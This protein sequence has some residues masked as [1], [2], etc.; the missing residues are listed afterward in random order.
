MKHSVFFQWDHITYSSFHNSASF[1]T[2]PRKLESTEIYPCH[3][4]TTIIQQ[5]YAHLGK[6][7]DY[8]L[9][10]SSHVNFSETGQ[11]VTAV[12]RETSARKAWPFLATLFIQILTM[13]QTESRPSIVKRQR[14]FLGNFHFQAPITPQSSKGPTI[15]IRKD[16]GPSKKREQALRA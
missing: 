2:M 4:R 7:Q 13:D 16:S 1:T 9:P 12:D 10:V 11:Y 5:A 6:V 15:G 3:K 8:H 14:K